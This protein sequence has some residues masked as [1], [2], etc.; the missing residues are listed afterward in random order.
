MK[1][2]ANTAFGL[3]GFMFYFLL[4]ATDLLSRS[5]EM[6]WPKRHA[7]C[8][9]PKSVGESQTLRFVLR[10]AFRLASH[11]LPKSAGGPQTV[12]SLGGC[13]ISGRLVL[14]LQ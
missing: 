10:P 7:V 6:A 11:L 12:A 9:L 2:V 1:V 4:T 5:R 8:S 13:K 14:S 3:G